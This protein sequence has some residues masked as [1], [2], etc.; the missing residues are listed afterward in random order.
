MSAI[1]PR[2]VN[3]RSIPLDHTRI[4]RAPPEPRQASVTER[5][6]AVWQAIPTVLQIAIPIVAVIGGGIVL[7][8]ILPRGV[9]H[10]L[11]T[12]SQILGIFAT[13]LG[14]I[15]GALGLSNSGRDNPG[16]LIP[17]VRDEALALCIA[18][19]KREHSTAHCEQ[20]LQRLQ[21]LADTFERTLP[22]LTDTSRS[23]DR[24][25]LEH[26]YFSERADVVAA[27]KQEMANM[28]TARYR[29][30]IREIKQTA[31]PAM[32]SFINDI[33]IE[34]QYTIAPTHY[35]RGLIEIANPERPREYAGRVNA[36]NDIIEQFAT[37]LAVRSGNPEAR[38]LHDLA[39]LHN[40]FASEC[41]R[42]GR[43]S[44]VEEYHRELRAKLAHYVSKVRAQ[45]SSSVHYQGIENAC[46]QVLVKL[47]NTASPE[48]ERLTFAFV[49]NLILNANHCLLAHDEAAMKS[50]QEICLQQE[51]TPQEKIYNELASY[52][53]HIVESYLPPASVE[54]I[55]VAREIVRQLGAEF[56]LRGSSRIHAQDAADM[57]RFTGMG[58][59]VHA[60]RER[61]RF[62]GYYNPASILH[63]IANTIDQDLELKTLV[64]EVCR[65]PASWT[66]D[67]I[68]GIQQMINGLRSA[69]ADDTTIR[70]ELQ[71]HNQINCDP[72]IYPTVEN[73]IDA[74]RLGLYTATLY[75]EQG[76]FTQG[77]ILQT[78]VHL[79]VLQPPS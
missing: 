14:L 65:A 40:N 23:N 36:L 30:M 15:V 74:Y 67:E 28:S 66:N 61:I 27:L 72:T 49:K 60:D 68:N 79:N 55:V 58:G 57:V 37:L 39:F 48:R 53:Y 46:L 59:D 63:W 11:S 22:P 44:T 3:S 70:Q 77:T 56:G 32:Q 29:D 42:Y 18:T 6:R 73:A 45:C 8:S 38:K 10:M 34:V 31:N 75:D 69:G 51:A 26:L 1:S 2:S 5:I 71:Q 64:Q 47:R 41:E 35:R 24:L 21:T 19:L 52:R 12:A 17:L 33:D 4:L 16:K 7:G 62:L 78:L 54:T 76:K 9:V 20:L 43:I 13:I 50:Y 25:Y